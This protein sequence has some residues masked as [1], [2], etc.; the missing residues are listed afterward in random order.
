MGLARAADRRLSA[1]L[2]GRV[3]DRGAS[4]ALQSPLAGCAQ[5]A[6][7]PNV[8]FEW[9][10]SKAP[11]NVVKHG[12]DFA[13]AA[14]VLGDELALTIL[15]DRDG[16]E[17]YVTMGCDALGRILVVVYTM[18]GDEIAR[19]ISARPAAA[20]ERRRYQEAP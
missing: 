14:T 1:V 6:Y 2:A 15:D 5:S 20:G 19:I 10:T 11:A 8:D 7:T 9:D 16:E 18:P 3:A 13:D 17:R 12:I 4:L